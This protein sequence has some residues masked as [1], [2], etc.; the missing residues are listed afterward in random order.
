MENL[1]KLIHQKLREKLNEVSNGEVLLREQFDE[2]CE[3]VSTEFEFERLK[4]KIEEHINWF[5]ESEDDDW[6]VGIAST[7]KH[8]HKRLGDHIKE[9]EN[10]GKEVKYFTCFFSDKESAIT[11]AENHFLNHADKSITEAYIGGTGG[12]PNEDGTP[13]QYI[14]VFKIV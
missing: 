3:S 11:D 12:R 14:Y 2:V 7:E 5:G 1:K 8:L 13:K 6:G 9:Y 4:E 10:E